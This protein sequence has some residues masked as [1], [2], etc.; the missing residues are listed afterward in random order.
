MTPVLV[1]V[2][3]KRGEPIETSGQAL[4][5]FGMLIQTQQAESLRNWVGH[6]DQVIRANNA[7]LDKLSKE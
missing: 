3:P 7:I 6:C 2:K 5:D 4:S 1:I